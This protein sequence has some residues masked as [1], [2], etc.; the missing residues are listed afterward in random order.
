MPAASDRIKRAFT[1]N[2]ASAASGEGEGHHL[3]GGERLKGAAGRLKQ[4]TQ[5]AADDVREHLQVLPHH[6]CLINSLFNQYHHTLI[7]AEK[8]H[9]IPYYVVEE[10][11]NT[12]SRARDWSLFSASSSS[13]VAILRSRLSSDGG[14]VPQLQAT[15]AKPC[16]IAYSFFQLTC[17]AKDICADFL[18]SQGVLTISPRTN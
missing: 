11:A 2:G 4:G 14:N 3:P 10:E 7:T 5:R 17:K 16:L 9:H 8:R 13:Y 15:A 12:I 1:R 6:K 18:A